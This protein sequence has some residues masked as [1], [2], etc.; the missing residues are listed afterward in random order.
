MLFILFQ[1]PSFAI[2]DLP[3][4]GGN[5]V[6]ANNGTVSV[7]ITIVDNIGIMGFKI[8][9]TYNADLLNPKDVLSGTVT[10]SGLLNNSIGKTKPGS[11]DIVWSSTEN[12][13]K[14]GTL[15][16]ITFDVL[17]TKNSELTL[18]Y[19]QPDTFDEN[20]NDVQLKCS[21]IKISFEESEKSDI[22]E[23]PIKQ[24]SNKDII[25][26]V[27]W[28]K[29]TNGDI[30]AE[31]NKT[32]FE[33]TGMEHY[34][35]NVDE[36]QESYSTAV[37][38]NFI[39]TAQ[40]SIDGSIIESVIEE[41]LKTF[42]IDTIDKIP[43]KSEQGFVR[44]VEVDLGEYSDELKTISDKISVEESVDT[45]RK[46]YSKNNVE[47][48]S[49][50]TVPET[51]NQSDISKNNKLYFIILLPIVLLLFLAVFLMVIKKKKEKEKS[52]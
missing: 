1:V 3:S 20:W 6:T 23:V 45:I 33:L 38:Q 26:A 35:N 10:Q 11:F 32:L 34:F 31:T 29:G 37:S 30:L 46:L 27:E 14:D 50:V 2:S 40:S 4:V 24:P 19:S 43:E 17:E 9:V 42:E 18:S 44:K 21:A 47:K 39:D 5:T 28:S 12:V 25:S 49:G 16:V 15:A 22:T 48:T 7:P 52:I 13:S 51:K 41:S 36:I 8:S